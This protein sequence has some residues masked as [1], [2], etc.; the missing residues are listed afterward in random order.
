MNTT[1]NTI[2]S[3]IKN[4]FD[5]HLQ[6]NLFVDMQYYDFNAGGQNLYPA[7]IL[8]PQLSNINASQINLNFNLFFSDLLN[9]DRS[10]TREVYSDMLD[11][12]R[13]F[14]SY[15]QT[16]DDDREWCIADDATVQPFEEQFDD[17]IVAGWVLNFTVEVGF[18]KNICDIP[19][20]EL[21]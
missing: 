1:Y 9:S 8:V 13:D 11:V 19:L 21:T 12:A 3:D 5:H 6:V 10:N 17:A 20:N 18:S 2:I 4:F 14:V 15:F 16:Y 7:T